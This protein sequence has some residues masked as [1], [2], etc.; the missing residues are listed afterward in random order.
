MKI[1]LKIYDSEE[2]DFHVRSEDISAWY[3]EDEVLYFIVGSETFETEANK[4]MIDK[5]EKI[6]E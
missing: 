5:F 4:Y 3:V 2:V 1:T 6:I